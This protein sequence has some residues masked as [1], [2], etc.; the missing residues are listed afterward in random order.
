MDLFDL[1]GT[2][3][4]VTGASGRLGPS[5]VTALVDAGATVVAVGRDR[6]R[7]AAALPEHARILLE[8]CD[9]T[10]PDWPALVERV[11]TEHGRLDVLVNNAHIG[12]GGSLRTATDAEWT[13]AWDLAVR[14]TE[15][16][17]SAARPFLAASAVAGGPASVVNVS[18][19]YGVRAPDP[20]MYEREEHRNPPYYGAAKAAL[21]QLSRYAAA[22]LAGDGI[23]VNALVLGPFPGSGADAALLEKIAA[24]TMLGRVGSPD[25]VAGAVLYLAS[26]ASSFTTGSELTVDGGWTAR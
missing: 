6:D 22:D 4:I 13:E 15:R 3:A 9:I 24:R 7:L 8:P 25:E 20:G 19:M 23:R 17:I 14:A 1:T 12:R 16:G 18:S 2:V 21:L 11:G 10:S 26:R 5:M